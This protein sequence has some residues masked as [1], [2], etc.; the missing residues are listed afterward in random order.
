MAT[1]EAFVVAEAEKNDPASW[2]REKKMWKRVGYPHAVRRAPGILSTTAEIKTHMVPLLQ[3]GTVV[4]IT[5]GPL[6]LGFDY[7]Q[8]FAVG[9]IESCREKRA[10][11]R[12]LHSVKKEYVVG[13][14]KSVPNWRIAISRLNK[15]PKPI[16]T[17]M[18]L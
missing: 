18:S 16:K 7:F 14:T 4:A 8:V 3:E 13:T 17:P 12:V 11:V 5:N 15:L 6:S 2:I 9:R 1:V 10:R